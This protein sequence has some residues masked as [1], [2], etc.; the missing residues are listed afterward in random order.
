MTRHI[1]ASVL[2]LLLVSVAW[3][4]EPKKSELS[5][6]A[7]AV[8][9]GNNQFATDLY[10]RLRT[11]EPTNLFFSPYSISTALAMTSA[12]AKGPTEKEMARVLH[13]SLPQDR[14]HPAMA[15]LSKTLTPQQKRPD[16]QLRVA[17][18]LWGQQGFRF[19]PPFLQI[20]KENY[21]AELGRVDFKLQTEKSRTEIN[22]WV[23]EQTEH[24]IKDLL[25][26]GV[27]TA[28]TRLV[29]TNAVY[30]KAPW[31]N[32]FNKS[33]TKDAPFHISNTKEATV[34]MM[35]RTGRFR[36]AELDELQI[37]ELPYGQGNVAMLALLPKKTT[38]LADLEKNLNGENLKKW[39]ADLKSRLVELTLPK[40]KMSASFS[41]K[42]VLES[43]GMKLAFSDR[44]DFT[45]ITTDEPLAISAVIHKAFVD[46]NEEGTEAAAATAV[47]IVAL[48][49]PLQPETPVPFRADHPFVFLLRDRATGSILFLGRLAN[50]KE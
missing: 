21:A 29:L 19:L 23:E 34:P 16:F 48:S 38:G 11:D 40:F 37:L 27:L 42:A 5:P 20:T 17:N 12:G 46:V 1:L 26:Q 22:T 47:T 14:V 44:A 30:F 10:A 4:A 43:L 8:A 25:A 3:A 33:E 50:P 35:H 9:E 28:D 32:E 15:Q 6:D 24:K 2:I 31:A 36:Y 41:L 7:K 49:A 13:F 45:G 39:T 18:R